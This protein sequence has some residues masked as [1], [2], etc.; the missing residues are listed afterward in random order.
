MQ[1]AHEKG[2]ANIGLTL[3][4]EPLSFSPA[5]PLHFERSNRLL[6]KTP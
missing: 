2:F 6:E 4:L 1:S 5:D 3:I